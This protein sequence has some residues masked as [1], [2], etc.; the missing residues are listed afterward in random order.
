MVSF[1]PEKT[2]PDEPTLSPRSDQSASRNGS[3]NQPLSLFPR[4]YFS[5]SGCA[6]NCAYSRCLMCRRGLARSLTGQKG[7]DA[8]YYSL[9]TTDQAW[10]NAHMNA[11]E[12]WIWGFTA[13]AV[14]AFSAIVCPFNGP[15]A[16]GL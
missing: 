13:V 6:P 15:L 4:I 9:E 7:Y 8:I 12:H 10:L 2:I 16:N 14:L 3:G 5:K 1:N 11:A